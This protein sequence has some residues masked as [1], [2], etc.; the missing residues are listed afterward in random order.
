M[1]INMSGPALP[2]ANLSPSETRDVQ[3]QDQAIQATGNVH[4]DKNEF[5]KLDALGI[6]VGGRVEVKWQVEPDGEEAYFR[7]WGATIVGPSNQ[8][9]VKRP[10]APVYELLYDAHDDFEQERGHVVFTGEHKLSQ[11]DQTDELTWRREGD[12]WDDYCDEDEGSEGPEDEGEGI[13]TEGEV[14][15]TMD[16]VHRMVEEDFAGQDMDELERQALQSLEPSKRI[17]V[18]A[19]FRDFADNLNEFL[20]ERCGNG[21]VVTADD[22]K[23]FME[24]RAKRRRI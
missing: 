19:E 4:D 7:W 16:D 15:Y 20:R 18:A 17:A 11:L 12:E 24:S 5:L 14:L 21:G 23:L 10:G 2:W 8:Q 13:T 1:N 9:D 3:Q 6:A 22:I